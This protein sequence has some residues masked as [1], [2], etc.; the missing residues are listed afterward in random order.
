MPHN[1]YSQSNMT[2]TNPLQ[3]NGMNNIML[4]PGTGEVGQ[5][6]SLS[7]GNA[8]KLLDEIASPGSEINESLLKKVDEAM[9]S[10]SLSD[11]VNDFRVLYGALQNNTGGV[12]SV[13]PQT[14]E[15]YKDGHELAR[16]LATRVR[17]DM[18]NTANTVFNF[19][20]YA[21]QKARE[22]RGKKKTRGNPFRVL[23][24]KI[25]KLLDHGLSKRD[26]VRYIGKEK[27]WDDETVEKAVG[28]V[29][30]YSKKKRKD[31]KKFQKDSSS[32][33]NLVKLAARDA[34]VSIYEVEPDFEKRSTGEL[35]ARATWLKDLST[36]GEKTPQGDG[37]KAANKDGLNAE[38][39]A[40]RA[41]LTKR[42]FEPNEL[43]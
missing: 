31:E 6:N 25:G 35:M 42:G 41:A 7:K 18:N 21:Q 11:Y 29:M 43:P 33:N 15:P 32:E 4:Q 22:D 24:G 28:V 10:P 19:T 13:D 38:L 5:T 1:S 36:Y 17:K 23:M 39:K 40:I 37:R 9:S 14:G 8:L 20:K 26:I 2:L 12:T 3:N 30:E 34:D 27:T 16:E